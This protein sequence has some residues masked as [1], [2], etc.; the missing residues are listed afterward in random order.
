M[1]GSVTRLLLGL[2]LSLLL[3][4]PVHAGLGEEV[5]LSVGETHRAGDPACIVLLES[6]S[7]RGS[8]PGNVSLRIRIDDEKTMRQ[9]SEDVQVRGGRFLVDHLDTVRH[10]VQLLGWSAEG[11]RLRVDELPGVPHETEFQLRPG[12]SQRITDI[13]WMVRFESLRGSELTLSVETDEWDQFELVTR[14]EGGAFE[15]AEKPRE[16]HA[17]RPLSLSGEV[18][19]L[20]TVPNQGWVQ[21]QRILYGLLGLFGLVVLLVLL[22]QARIAV[23]LLREQWTYNAAVH[24]HAR[25]EG[26]S[27]PP[28]PGLHL[29]IN[30][31][32]AGWVIASLVA[33]FTLGW[34]QALLMAACLVPFGYW[35][36]RRQSQG[37]DELAERHGLERDGDGLKGGIDGRAVAYGSRVEVSHFRSSSS[38]M[39]DSAVRTTLRLSLLHPTRHTLSLDTGDDDRLL[40]SLDL[41]SPEGREVVRRLEAYPVT[42]V[43][44]RSGKQLRLEDAS[45]LRFDRGSYGHA[46]ELDHALQLLLGLARLLEKS[47]QD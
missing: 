42:H 8:A 24:E 2:S 31:V 30:L 45:T 13:G 22:F 38:G 26:W 44:F 29:L 25:R 10:R 4:I 28:G 3:A 37:L 6:S 34:W 23:R 16:Q 21:G 5:V 40:T 7:P 20:T 17:L 18:L 39:K 27:L 43:G 41:D 46:A 36:L 15:P 33:F 19:T 47:P 9:T 32:G 14:H 1:I 35:L 12:E 11:L